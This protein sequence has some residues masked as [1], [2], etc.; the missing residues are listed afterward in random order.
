MLV[1]TVAALVES[2]KSAAQASLGV[3]IKKNVA[4]M[5]ETYEAESP[6]LYGLAV[7]DV[8]TAESIEPS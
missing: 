2:P 5:K 7:P 3:A 6:Q 8:A 1:F 4:A